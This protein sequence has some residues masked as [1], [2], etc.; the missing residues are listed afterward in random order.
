MLLKGLSIR[1]APNKNEF[2]KKKYLCIS[3]SIHIHGIQTMHKIWTKENGAKKETMK[4]KH[5]G[6]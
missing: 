1:F 3:L 4:S 5:Q 6:M 2:H